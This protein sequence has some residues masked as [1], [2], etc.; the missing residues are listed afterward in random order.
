MK[1]LVGIGRTNRNNYQLRKSRSDSQFEMV[2]PRS[3]KAQRRTPVREAQ[4]KF[5][6]NRETQNFR[7][8]EISMR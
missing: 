7:I 3:R 5:M 6:L 2:E 4:M 8:F 1:K